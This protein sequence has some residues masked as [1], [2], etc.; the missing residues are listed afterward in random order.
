MKKLIVLVFICLFIFALLT[1]CNLGPQ[2]PLIAADSIF[3]PNVYVFDTSMDIISVQKTIDTVYNNQQNSQFGSNRFA[4]LFKPGT[5]S[6]NIGVGYYTEVLGL[7][8]YPDEV[9]ITGYLHSDAY[10]PNNNSTCNFWRGATNFSVNPSNGSVK[11]AV[12]QAIWFR[13]M[14]VQ[15]NMALHQNGGWASGGWMANT[16][17][18]GT[19]DSG[20]QQQWISRNTTWNSWTGSNWNMVFVGVANAPPGDWP[21]PVYTKIALVPIVRE[22]PFIQ[23]DSGG[24]YSV[25]V[26]SL[27]SNT[28]GYDWAG[29]SV[30]G[31]TIPIDDFYIAMAGTDTAASINTQLT[32]GKNL[33]LTPGIYNLSETI[34][35]ANA[36]TVVLG[37]GLATLKPTTGLAAMTIADVDGVTVSGVLFDAGTISSPVLLKVGTEGN[38]TSHVSNPIVLHDLIFRV[39]GAAAGKAAISFMINAYD[40]IVDHTWV[41]RA[42]HGFGVGWTSNTAANGL[43]VNGENV[44]IYGLFVEH[45]QEFQTVWNGDG[46]RVYFYQSEIPYDPP[47]Q[48]AWRSDTGVNGWASYKV[49]DSVTSHEA[50]GLGIYS[51]FSNLGVKL[52]RAIEVPDTANVNFHHM[53]TVCIGEKGEI[54]HVINDTGDSTGVNCSYTP[55]VNDYP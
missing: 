32:A 19:V 25:R 2:I 6:V 40:T 1:G 52:S 39:G 45:Y 7:G 33:I 22:K 16:L 15:G 36:N 26:P 37:M 18:N 17:V 14:H 42:D 10:L 29:G 3:G 9:S 28:S 8:E 21:S 24:I 51:V 48:D 47:N 31:T 5:Y 27:K 50:W 38:T 55:K 30:P 35:I 54:T 23:V 53:I 13:Q 34:N 20:P 12:S 44:T 4:L 43:V 46:G 41:W 11:W 49:V